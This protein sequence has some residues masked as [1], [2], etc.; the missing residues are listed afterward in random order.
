VHFT[1]VAWCGVVWCGVVCLLYGSAGY[2][3]SKLQQNIGSRRQH[4]LLLLV[5]L[6]LV[7]IKSLLVFSV[8]SLVV[9][10]FFLYVPHK[11]FLLGFFCPGAVG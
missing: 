2:F 3:C 5:L 6:L 11:D 1:S 4:L 7:G 10:G 8:F 9:V